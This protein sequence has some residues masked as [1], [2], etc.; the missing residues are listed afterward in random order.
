MAQ[1]ELIDAFG[2]ILG[3]HLIL[4][5]IDALQTRGI[6]GNFGENATFRRFVIVIVIVM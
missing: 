5:S 6:G 4:G 3:S 1:S 2:S